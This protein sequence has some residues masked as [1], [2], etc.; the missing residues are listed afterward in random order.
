MVAPTNAQNPVDAM[1]LMQ[2]YDGPEIAA[3]LAEYSG[4][5]GG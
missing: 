2:W 1:T 4:P 5:T 3:R